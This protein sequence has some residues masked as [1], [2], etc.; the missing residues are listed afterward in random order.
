MKKAVFLDRD[1]TIIHDRNYLR[2]PDD[3]EFLGGA[4]EA[5]KVLK[6]AGFLLI[7]C[8]NQSAIARGV[9]SERKYRAID[10]RF[11]EMLSAQGVS[12]DGTYYC[13]HLPGG[14]VGKYALRCECR[15]PKKGM[16]IAAQKG[17]G[18]DF[19]ASYAVGDSVRDLQ[20][21]RTLG[22]TTI[23]VMTGKG[24]EVLLSGRSCLFANYICKDLLAASR[25][26][27]A[28]AGRSAKMLKGTS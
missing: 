11:K 1:G 6:S 27:V 26:I 10:R 15:K 20:P 23:L 8:T 14:L 12:I 18:I 13:P 24:R 9:I 7:V 19:S 16:F 17:F 5:L 2:S 22:A 4:V 28:L 25:K 21:V 3:I